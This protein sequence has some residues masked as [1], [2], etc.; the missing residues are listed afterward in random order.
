MKIMKNVKKVK[1]M[2][3][4]EDDEAEG[5]EVEYHLQSLRGFLSLLLSE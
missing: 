5:E 1:K 4:N 2:I 3:E